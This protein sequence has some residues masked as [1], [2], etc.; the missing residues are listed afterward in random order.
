MPKSITDNG[1]TL[2]LADV[3]WSSAE[4]TDGEGGIVTHYTA[5]AV[6]TGSTTSTY[7]TGYTA[8]ICLGNVCNALQTNIFLCS[9]IKIRRKAAA[10]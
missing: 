8:H 1:K 10:P 3:Q 2:K 7:A 4:S 9:K 6:Y 5:T